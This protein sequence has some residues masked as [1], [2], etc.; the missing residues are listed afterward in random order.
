MTKQRKQIITAASITLAAIIIDQIIK[1]L[2]KT[3]MF[4]HEVIEITPWFK[5]LFTENSGMAF[6]IEL[7]DK[8]F[9]TSFRLVAVSFLIYII[10]SIIKRGINTGFLIC[11]SLILAG[12]TGNIIDCL[13]YGMIFNNPPA[14]IV[15][16]FVPFGTGYASMFY[17][18]VVD[19]FYF[20]LVEWNWPSWLP[21]I[22]GEHFIFFSPIFN[23][24]DACISCSVIYM[25]L[26]YRKQL[27]N[28]M[29]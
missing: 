7:V 4:M 8:I 29:K 10:G 5:I 18:K 21:Y 19:M 3:N 11:M 22:G 2:V 20:P 25:L 17:G 28:I 12:A 6:G 1:I 26:F 16:E 14:P 15:A 23:F 24:A 13:F 27:Q 9:L